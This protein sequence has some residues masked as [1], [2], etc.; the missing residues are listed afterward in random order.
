MSTDSIDARAMA[1][2]SD[3]LDQPS[4]LRREW[5]KTAGA[6]DADITARVLA[7]L[8]IDEGAGSRVLRT[9]GAGQDMLDAPIPE[10]IGPYRIIELIGRGGMGAVYKATR[11]IEN[12]DHA[13]AIKIIR[14]GAMVNI[15]VERFQRE[16]QILANL[17]HPNIARLY[18]GDQT[19][20]G[21]PYI[22]MEY[23]DGQPLP[24]WVSEQKLPIED[25]L[26]LFRDLCGAVR[27]AHQ[28]LIIHRDLTPS[29]VLVTRAG[30]V[31]LIDFGIA[32]PHSEDELQNASGA[33]SL[34]NLSFTPGFAAPERSAGAAPNTL[35]DIFSLGK[36]LEHL[37]DGMALPADLKAII[38]KCAAPDPAKRYASVDGLI[39]DLDNL[40]SNRPVTARVGGA[41]YRLGKF[42][43]RR[44]LS[45]LAASA[46][47]IGLTTAFT[48]TLIQYQRAETARAQADQRFTDVRDL[49]NF[50]LFDLF[51]KLQAIHG[52]TEALESIADRSR[53]YLDQLSKTPGADIDLALE[54]A[55]GYRRLS[56]VSG[57][58]I[59]GN[60]G[61]REEARAL[62]M[63]AMEQISALHTRNPD[64]AD[65]LR[66]LGDI[67]FSQS[68]FEY[69]VENNNEDSIVSAVEGL[70]AYDKLLALQP[71]TYQDRLTRNRIAIHHARPFIWI[72]RSA[73]SV[74]LFKALLDPINSLLAEN[75][76]HEMARA[77][78]AAY[79]SDYA[80]ALSWHKYFEEADATQALELAQ[81]AVEKY[82][83]IVADTKLVGDYRRSL[84]TNI[85]LRGQIYADMGNYEAALIDLD[86]AEGIILKLI[87]ADRHDTSLIDVLTAIRKQKMADLSGAGR[88]DEAII[89]SEWVV[90]TDQ[91]SAEE[92]LD[93][94]GHWSEYGNTLYILAEVYENAGRP[95]DACRTSQRALEAYKQSGRDAPLPEGTIR[96]AIEPLNAALIKCKESGLIVQE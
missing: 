81:I 55:I 59:T 13:V 16:R 6:G 75:P 76:D 7:L 3:A 47:I 44:R 92:N 70:A 52:N 27:Y 35:S 68:V 53:I 24:Q 64:N 37:L 50:M 63:S 39:D 62:L 25:R 28:N 45:V 8:D 65:I 67:K 93:D 66:A 78:E 57:N 84:A 2:M 17:N 86:E 77:L 74:A 10:R 34:S 49:A 22:V 54:T 31:K 94:S 82:R 88:N 4:D 51:D 95:G 33:S 12:F 96:F 73:Q 38:S 87:E 89:L 43:R 85:Y 14:P 20:S 79:Y 56:D 19:E 1:L 9:G 18:D 36:L 21:E 32:K 26:W 58:P 83:T 69:I 80:E 71:A 29:N 90:Q 15:L 30:M 40:A 42:L 48:S 5:V 46:F 91:R 41:K 23:I 61:R 60:L 11:G 72:D